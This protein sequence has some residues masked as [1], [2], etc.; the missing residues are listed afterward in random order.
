M[1]KVIP[2]PEQKAKGFGVFPAGSIVDMEPTFKARLF[3]DDEIEDLK[4]MQDRVSNITNQVSRS[5][6]EAKEKAIKKYLISLG[7]TPPPVKGVVSESCLVR[8]ADREPETTYSVEGV[9]KSIVIAM[10]DIQTNAD[11]T[12]WINSGE[13]VFERLWYI[14]TLHGGDEEVL[15]E[16]FPLYA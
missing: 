7:W 13:T 4:C 10:K 2:T 15:K 14:Y 9:L 11:D 6:A 3:T 16:A 5:I 12:L 1:N 8:T